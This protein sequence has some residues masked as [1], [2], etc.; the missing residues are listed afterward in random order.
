MDQVRLVE[1]IRHFNRFYTKILGLLDQKFLHSKYSLAEARI[2]FELSRSNNLAAKDLVKELNI[3]PSYLS[4]ILRKFEQN[5]LLTRIS[6]SKDSRKQLIELTEKGF[7]ILE[8]LREL[9]NRQI[10]ARLEP[11]SE[12]EK[13]NLLSSMKLIERLLS[14][15]KETE[16]L[17]SIRYH[18]PGD[19]GYLTYQH[20]RYYSREY[21]LDINFDVYVAEAMVEFIKNYNEKMERLWIVEQGSQ[22][23]GSVAIV[24]AEQ[25]I[26][27]LRWFLLEPEIHGKG[28][29]KKLLQNALR[30]CNDRP[31][32]KIILWTFEDLDSARALYKKEN[33]SLVKTETHQVWGQTLTEELWELN[34]G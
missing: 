29:G 34:L 26:A 2:L 24:Q 18:Q 13:A 8:Q 28:I 5:D 20:S 10:E 4:R 15:N 11:L 9:T 21:G 25:E 22:I 17:I 6:S 30:F 1:D 16:D 12:Q 23:M 27:Q 31:Y 19:I 33:F 32:K 3:D 14:G 7:S